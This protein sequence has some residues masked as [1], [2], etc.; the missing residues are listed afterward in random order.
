MDRMDIGDDP[1][2]RGRANEFRGSGDCRCE[3][4]SSH[5]QPVRRKADDV[6]I[7]SIGTIEVRLDF[8]YRSPGHGRL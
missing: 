5:D 8:G 1:E 3:G 6:E 7:R 4:W 2:K